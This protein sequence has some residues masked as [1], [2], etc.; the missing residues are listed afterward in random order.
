MCPALAT[1]SRIC[2]CLSSAALSAVSLLLLLSSDFREQTMAACAAGIPI[3]SWAETTR[4]FR[5]RT[6]LFRPHQEGPHHH[7]SKSNLGNLMGSNI[8]LFL[9][10]MYRSCVE[11][12]LFGD[13]CIHVGR[14]IVAR[15]EGNALK[16]LGRI[17]RNEA[18][19]PARSE[20][21][22]VTDKEPTSNRRDP[23]RNTHVDD[24]EDQTTSL[25][26]APRPVPRP[27]APFGAGSRR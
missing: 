22:K 4:D 12:T 14:Q 10:F 19:H 20:T 25:R 13:P 27:A 26:G 18:T 6:G 17:I 24:V 16:T 15:N 7:L 23:V 5:S 8:L 21:K 2:D 1:S 3:V 11:T 9:G